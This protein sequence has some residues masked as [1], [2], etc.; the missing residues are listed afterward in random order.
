MARYL[1]EH[2][3]FTQARAQVL[4]E[5]AADE[6]PTHDAMVPA[7]S[8]PTAPATTAAS[9][10]ASS[11]P[12]GTAPPVSTPSASKPHSPRTGE[13]KSAPSGRM[14]SDFIQPQL[15]PTP[16]AMQ[17]QLLPTSAAMQSQLLPTSAAMQ[18]QLLPA[19]ATTQPHQ[20]LA[21]IKTS[22]SASLPNDGEAQYSSSEEPEGASGAPSG[23]VP[24]LGPGRVVMTSESDQER[25]PRLGKRR[26][27]RPK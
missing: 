7:S 18:P 2:L 19:S 13:G 25:D 26:K 5:E 11:A 9:A 14:L 4:L 10:A 21:T 6:L 1:Q 22:A 23:S 15:L 8:A 20:P 17:P 24:P 3:S 16:A 12:T 27:K